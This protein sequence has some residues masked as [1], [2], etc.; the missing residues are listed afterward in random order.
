VDWD[1][2]ARRPSPPTSRNPRAAPESW[3]ST[4]WTPGLMIG[5]SLSSSARPVIE[6]IPTVVGQPEW[7]DRGQ[8][9]VSMARSVSRSERSHIP[10]RL[11]GPIKEVRIC[12]EREPANRMSTGRCSEDVKVSRAAVDVQGT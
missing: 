9:P 7:V 10:T 11:L 3:S 12:Q 5:R 4:F 8:I 6:V 2:R 1:R